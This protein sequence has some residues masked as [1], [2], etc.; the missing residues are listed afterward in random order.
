MRGYKNVLMSRTSFRSSSSISRNTGQVPL[1]G[2]SISL[3]I[4]VALVASALVVGAY[5]ERVSTNTATQQEISQ[6]ASVLSM[7]QHDNI[8]EADYTAQLLSKMGLPN[9][10]FY[11]AG[12]TT[13]L[14]SPF[15]GTITIQPVPVSLE[16]AARGPAMFGYQRRSV[17]VDQADYTATGDALPI[18]FGTYIVKRNGAL[19]ITLADA[20]TPGITAGA[21][22]TGADLI[23]GFSVVTSNGLSDVTNLDGNVIDGGNLTGSFAIQGNAIVL[24]NV[25]GQAQIYGNA[26]VSGNVAGQAQINGCADVGGHVSGGAHIGGNLVDDGNLTGNVSVSGSVDVLGLINGNV[27]IGASDPGAACTVGVP[28]TPIYSAGLTSTEVT[29]TETTLSQGF[30]ALPANSTIPSIASLNGNLNNVPIVATPNSQGVAVFN[31]DPSVFSQYASYTVNPNGAKSIIFNVSGTGDTISSNFE[32]VSSVASQIVW[33]F[34][35]AT[36]INLPTQIGGTIIAPLATVETGNQVLGAVFAQTFNSGGQ[37]VNAPYSGYLPPADYLTSSQIA[38][39]AAGGSPSS[40]GSGSTSS[41][42]SSGSTTTSSSGTSTSDPTEGTTS[43]TPTSSTSTGSTDSGSSTGTTISST[44]PTGT[45]GTTTGSGG[46][47][48]GIVATNPPP[49]TSSP[50]QGTSGTSAGG[51]SSVGTGSGSGTITVPTGT[52]LGS[53][54]GG[55]NGSS[56]STPSTTSQANPVDAMITLS[57]A[58]YSA[59]VALAS[60]SLSMPV[61]VNGGTFVHDGSSDSGLPKS[62]HSGANTVAWLKL[63]S[64]G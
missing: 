17:T 22:L 20:T 63:T 23:A 27:T 18:D 58:P 35:T 60:A 2:L 57:D 53:T 26:Q 61:S 9:D 51:G 46:G 38:S 1:F 16:F 6:V 47:S 28:S 11:T 37:V 31:V 24:G 49:P 42:G 56:S 4:G 15:G 7:L 54:G 50:T 5:A 13:I 8:P 33:N 43:T 40:S 36:N 29:Q 52:Q 41:T 48:S 55:G 12:G 64:G 32:N 25:V 62:C 14:R 34:P 45:S 19:P 3:I 21:N 30:S 59:C 44:T 39:A 10:Y